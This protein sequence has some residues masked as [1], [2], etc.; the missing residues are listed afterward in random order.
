M[1]YQQHISNVIES[2]AM[3][4]IDT[5][6]EAGGDRVDFEAALQQARAAIL[7]DIPRTGRS[8]ALPLAN[9]PGGTIVDRDL[10]AR[11]ASWTSNAC[12]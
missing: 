1:D 8:Q 6:I 10:R 7:R 12:S 3:G 9:T 5:A 11:A 4:A 2:Y